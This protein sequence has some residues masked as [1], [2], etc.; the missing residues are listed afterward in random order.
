MSERRPGQWPVD[1]PTDLD[2]I[3]QGGETA[4]TLPAEKGQQIVL[5]PVEEQGEQHQALV[6]D[7]ARFHVTLGSVRADLEE[8]P[9][10]ACIRAAQRRWQ[11][12]ISQIADETAR[13]LRRTG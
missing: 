2:A 7:Q 1:E 3:E 10:E 4:P 6:H 12:A 9:S 11:N 5:T 13:L 8:Q